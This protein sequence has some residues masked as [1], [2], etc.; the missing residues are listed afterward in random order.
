MFHS[1]PLASPHS[2][3]RYVISESHLY[4]VQR[5]ILKNYDINKGWQQKQIKYIVFL[6]SLP[7]IIPDFSLSCIFFC[8][9]SCYSRVTHFLSHIFAAELRS[10]LV[11]KFYFQFIIP[12]IFTQDY[13]F[14]SDIAIFEL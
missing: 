3:C 7:G 2:V 14:S 8:I 9:T 12:I 4:P 11:H 13:Y 5:Y 1:H 10:N 6:C